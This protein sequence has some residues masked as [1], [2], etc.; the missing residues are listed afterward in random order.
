[1]SRVVRNTIMRRISHLL[2]LFVA[3]GASAFPQS[4]PWGDP[5]SHQVQFITVQEGVEL[6]VLDWGGSG[7]P[8]VLLAG[9]NTAHVFDDFAVKLKAFGHI[10]GITRRGFGASSRPDTGYTAQRSAQ[11]VLKVLDSL[12]LGLPILIGHDYGGQDA[13]LLAAQHSD[14]IGAVV[15]L[16]AEDPTLDIWKAIGVDPAKLD[17][18][19]KKLP[20][21]MQNRLP[22]DYTSFQAFRDRQIHNTGIAFPE[23]ELRQTFTAN[24]DGSMGPYVGSAPV[25]QEALFKNLHKI[26]YAHI[27]APLLAFFR[28]PR[29]L[30]D[31]IRQ[32]QPQTSV[33]RAAMEQVHAANLA[34]VRKQMDVFRNGMPSS[35]PIELSGASHYDFLSSEAEVLRELR[36]FIRALRQ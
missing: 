11:D 4:P 29:P 33:E 1:M 8:I 20:A 17:E 21:A 23:A 26:D 28:A 14:S 10:Y 16:N 2:A 22:P 7:P 12:K 18:A 24:P 27:R 6:E 25:V 31:E 30:Q 9:F 36:E 3:I 13:L 35:R 32:N 5:S 19:R 34:F 15:Y